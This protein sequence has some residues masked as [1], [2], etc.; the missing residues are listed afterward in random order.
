VKRVALSAVLSTFVSLVC[1]GLGRAELAV[2]S[3]APDR[4]G[5]AS[6]RRAHRSIIA[7]G[8]ALA[9]AL[10]TVFFR[11]LRRPRLS[12]QQDEANTFVEQDVE[13]ELR[14]RIGDEAKAVYVRLAVRNRRLMRTAENVEVVV[15]RAVPAHGEPLPF[16][17]PGLGWAG[18]LEAPVWRTIGPGMRRVV[19]LGYVREQKGPPDDANPYRFRF[20][21]KPPP[22]NYRNHLK[23]RAVGRSILTSSA[24]TR[25]PSA[26]RLK[27]S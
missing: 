4:T 21:V 22:K 20:A 15:V 11:A 10:G 7:A 12:L 18:S 16:P 2:R 23:H 13:D 9:I 25:N 27:S 5:L 26:T 14:H 24:K 1:Q 19:D 6:S 3:S 8:V 17:S